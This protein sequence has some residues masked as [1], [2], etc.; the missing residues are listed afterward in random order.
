MIDTVDKLIDAAERAAEI[1]GKAYFMAEYLH[2]RSVTPPRLVLA[3]LREHKAA[4][5]YR[6]AEAGSDARRAAA[7][8]LRD[9][10]RDVDAELERLRS[11][12]RELAQRW[13]F[14]RQEDDHAAE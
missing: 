13:A 2:F 6:H 1:E 14:L 5:T 4:D 9:A 7:E 11:S 12:Y 3:L 10:Y 8:S